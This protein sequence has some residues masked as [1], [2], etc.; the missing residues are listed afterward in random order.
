MHSYVITSRRRIP[1][2][3]LL[4]LIGETESVEFDFSP[5]EADNGSVTGVTWTVESGSA[6]VSGEAL[7]SSVASASITTASEGWSLIK[8]TATGTNV[9]PIYL[10]V[11]CR[12][13]KEFIRDYC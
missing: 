3:G 8:I 13:P 9:F 5:W 4:T 12:D 6:A 10:R 2:R 7:A 11:L 1:I